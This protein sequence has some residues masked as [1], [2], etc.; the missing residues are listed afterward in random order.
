MMNHAWSRWSTTTL[1][2]VRS[3]LI[4]GVCLALGATLTHA[5]AEA[6]TEVIVRE[7]KTQPV[8][9]YADAIRETVYVETPVDSDAD[10][11]K[12]RVA[13][14][15][16]R[17]KETRQGLKVASIVEA[18]P[19]FGGLVDAPYHPVDVTDV[20]RLSPWSPPSGPWPGVDYARTN[21]D[22]Y[23]VSRGY[24]VLSVSGLG[25]GESDGCPGVVGTDEK[26]AVKSVIE[27]LTGRA[28]AFSAD[29]TA[30]GADWSTKNVAM[31]GGAYNASLA[32]AVAGTGVAGLKTVV[33]TG[34][35]SSWYEYYRANGGVV[36]PGGYGGEDAD[37]HAKV[38]LTRKNPGVCAQAVHRI[39]REM[40]R[41]SGDYNAF[42]HER[43]FVKDVPR[44]KASVF[45]VGSVGDWNVK[46]K[47]FAELWKALERNDVPRRLWLARTPHVDILHSRR[48]VWT[49]AVHQWFDHWLYGV[50]NG[51]L[52]EPKVQVE[53][54]PTV[55]QGYRNWPDPAA[56][57]V[58]FRFGA[59]DSRAQ[60]GELAQW[61]S[62]FGQRQ[63]F[64]DA[65]G[66]TADE[67]VADTGDAD[68]NRLVYLTGP[69]P[70]DVRISGVPEVTLRASVTG[71]SPYLTAL[72]VDYGTDTRPTGFGP[73]DESWCFGDSVPG[74]S[75]CRAIY[76][77]TTAQTPYQ[78]VSRGWL[79]VRNRHSASV[80]E[81]L[82]PDRTYTLRW[83]LQP[84]EYRF[85]AGHR[86]GV[87]LISTDRDFTLRYPA[88]TRI[89]AQ[90]GFS[91]LTLPVAG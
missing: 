10:G 57:P 18:S 73:T 3:G 82:S 13:A 56:R 31:A 15:V 43:N 1:W 55:W 64:V 50:R 6:A 91:E 36:A 51:A 75:G 62:G 53:T 17:P 11:R 34:S 37:L 39:E 66:R 76:R 86:L 35:V 79:D 28:S 80:T 61:P 23:F 22:N 90:L 65:P 19:Y 40:N 68:P 7:G 83:D 46:P 67:L 2:N 26:L 12:D 30:V 58:T 48:Q 77:Y 71:P 9:S 33:A 52:S 72:L 8:F 20:P 29:G 47:Q 81:P 21:Y 88:G 42:W 45:Q 54:E 60:P 24:A 59:G 25:T 84:Q 87:V 85:K 41:A 70:K 5:T 32:L 69:L 74:N 27:W 38:V 63:E 16:T 14:Y 44:F 4:V 49:D 89:S 78:V